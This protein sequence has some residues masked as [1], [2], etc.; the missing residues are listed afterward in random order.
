MGTTT[1]THPIEY[2]DFVFHGKVGYLT[3]NILVDFPGYTV[4]CNVSGTVRK[5]DDEY[6]DLLLRVSHIDPRDEGDYITITDKDREWLN[7][8]IVNYLYSILL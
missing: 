8:E 7:H 2:D 4:S 3:K 1:A 6:C 5:H